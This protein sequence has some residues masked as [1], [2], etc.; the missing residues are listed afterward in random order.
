MKASFSAPF[1]AL[2]LAACLNAAESSAPDQSKAFIYKKT[3]Q[4]DL[5]LLVDYPPGWKASDKRPAIVFFFGGGWTHGS[6][7]QFKMQAAYMANRGLV[8]VRADYR[9]G[10]RDKTTPLECI[11]DARSAVRWLRQHA[12]EQGI[13][14][15][16]II[17][18]GESAGGHL[19]ACT[20]FLPGPDSASDD[21][22]VS[23]KP[24]A[25]VLF[26]PPVDFSGIPIVATNAEDI[27]MGR[28]MGLFTVPGTAAQTNAEL[29]A[30]AMKMSPAAFLTAS[31]PPAILFFGT[32]DRSLEQGRR[33]T[34]K[35][36]KLG[37]RVEFYTALGV[38]HGFLIQPPWREITLKQAD[39]FLASLG[40]LQG[41]PTVQIP[42]A[43]KT[44]QAE[45]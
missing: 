16:R 13:D 21:L 24:C 5:K 41:L 11:E 22:S 23:C 42:D 1:F 27:A 25:L 43:T 6:P 44:L 4:I 29:T 34:E 37:N 28:K 35:S 14:P 7:G 36:R 30:M 45:K 38:K 18:A 33:F 12:A 31:A 32:A 8:A 19:A 17:A 39:E 3:P 40:L 15:D 26:D 10:D 20:A 9:I 2:L